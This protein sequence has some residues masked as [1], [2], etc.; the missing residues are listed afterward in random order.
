[1]E[2][3]HREVK[4]D[5]GWGAPQVRGEERRLEHSCGIAVLAS[6]LLIRAGQQE[7]RPGTSWS[8]AQLQQAFRLRIITTQIAHNVKT[9]RTKTRKVA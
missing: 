2:Q 8:L 6:L 7:M 9:R 1:M 3:I 4:T 5:L